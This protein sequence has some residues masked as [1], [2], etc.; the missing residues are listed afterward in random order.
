[1]SNSVNFEHEFNRHQSGQLNGAQVRIICV[2]TFCQLQRLL[3]VQVP[4]DYHNHKCIY[5]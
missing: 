3:H 5:L 1:M 4:L 2:D